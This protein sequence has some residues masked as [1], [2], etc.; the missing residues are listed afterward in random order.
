[1]IWSIRNGSER[2]KCLLG[3][4]IAIPGIH[5]DLL[6]L[7]AGNWQRQDIFTGISDKVII[8]VLSKEDLNIQSSLCSLAKLN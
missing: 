1:M 2:L 3:I 6:Q 7:M 8:S 5:Y 4:C